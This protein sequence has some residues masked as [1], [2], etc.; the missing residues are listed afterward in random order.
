MNGG[1][2]DHVQISGRLTID[3]VTNLFKNGLQTNSKKQLVVDLAQVQT[4]D[5]AAVSLLLSWLREA[6]QK[7]VELRFAH[8][9]ENL[10]SL[11]RLYG[12]VD[13]LPLCGNDST[14]P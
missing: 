2:S 13:M 7:N 4:V 1:N 8:I 10:L 9:P 6:Q 5:S 11:A 3:T 12:V 14:H